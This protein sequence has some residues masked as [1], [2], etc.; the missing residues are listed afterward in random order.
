MHEYDPGVNILDLLAECD[1]GKPLARLQRDFNFHRACAVEDDGGEGEIV[2]KLKYK[3]LNAREMPIS[4]VGEVKPKAKKSAVDTMVHLD[5]TEDGVTMHLTN[6]RQ[7]TM[8]FTGPSKVVDF[9][10]RSKN[11]ER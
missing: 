9:P 11:D 3:V 6:R 1:E 4:V 2:L 10:Q 8:E 7:T 5:A